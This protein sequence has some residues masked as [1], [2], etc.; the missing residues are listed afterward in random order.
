MLS[1]MRWKNRWLIDSGCI[2]RQWSQC[3]DSSGPTFQCPQDIDT[4]PEAVLLWSEG[5]LASQRLFSPPPP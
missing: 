1:H 3:W 5:G 4:G 2:V